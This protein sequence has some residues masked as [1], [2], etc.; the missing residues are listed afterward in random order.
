MDFIKETLGDLETLVVPGKPGGGGI[1]LCHGYGANAFDLLPLAGQLKAPA[2]THWF[3]PQA[4][5]TF[6]IGPDME[7][8]A[9]FPLVA[10]MLERLLAA[11]QKITYSEVVPDGLK[12]GRARLH[13]MVQATNIPVPRLTLGGFSQGSMLTTDYALRSGERPAGLIILSGTLICE[14]E[15]R[16]LASSLAGLEFFQTHGTEDPILPYAN[17]RRLEELLRAGGMTGEFLSF[18]GGHAIPPVVQ[19]KMSAYLMRN[20]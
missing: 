19:K 5:I 10:Q 18:P 11:G 12:E 3:F 20:A 8:R 16:P 6:P 14:H 2:G 13:S 17:A 1:I 15:W 4:P 9:W 7:G